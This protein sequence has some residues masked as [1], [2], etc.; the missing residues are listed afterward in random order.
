MK[1]IY[2]VCF[3]IENDRVRRKVGEELLAYGQ[4]VQ[5]S[6]FEIALARTSQLTQLKARLNKLF[7]EADNPSD[8]LRFYN[9]NAVTLANSSTL[10]NQPVGLFPSATVL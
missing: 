5:Y 1:H 7:A 4:R 3:D 10:D 8:D 9:L 6:V 2:L